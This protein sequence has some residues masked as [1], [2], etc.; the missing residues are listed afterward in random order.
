[1][2][3]PIRIF[4]TR[5]LRSKAFNAETRVGDIALAHDDLGVGRWWRRTPEG[6]GSYRALFIDDDYMFGT[7][8]AQLPAVASVSFNPRNCEVIAYDGLKSHNGT[9]HLD[10]GILRK[11]V[12]RANTWREYGID[13]SIPLSELEY[14]GFVAEPLR[15]RST[16]LVMANSPIY[17]VINTYMIDS[18]VQ[19]PLIS[20]REEV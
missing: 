2:N 7:P 18:R 3:H 10:V 20:I 9:E 17:K 8:I 15:G 19:S 12:S 4:T 11:A 14:L 1:M 16:N 5:T 13:E 6:W